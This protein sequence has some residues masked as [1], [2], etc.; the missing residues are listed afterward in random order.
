[1]ASTNTTNDW[2]PTSRPNSST[3]R[4]GNHTRATTG[5]RPS[6]RDL[7]LA[8]QQYLH[9]QILRD[10]QQPTRSDYR[11][12]RKTQTAGSLSNSY[13]GPEQTS[14]KYS[15]PQ[16]LP[17]TINTRDARNGRSWR[18]LRKIFDQRPK[19]L[20]YPQNRKTLCSELPA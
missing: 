1:M 2:R 15:F 10:P 13:P 12:G 20:C 3:F 16:N 4:Q 8:E 14:R 5:E 9:S 19:C 18:L 17:D 6:Y 7:S 11:G